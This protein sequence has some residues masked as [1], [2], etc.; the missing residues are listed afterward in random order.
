M[1]HPG[2]LQGDRTRL[3]Y[4]WYWSKPCERA[5]GSHQQTTAAYWDWPFYAAAIAVFVACISCTESS[6]GINHQPLQT[7]TQLVSRDSR[8]L[9]QVT[10][11]S[12][13]TAVDIKKGTVTAEILINHAHGDHVDYCSPAGA[14]WQYDLLIGSTVAAASQLVIPV[15]S[16]ATQQPFSVTLPLRRLAQR[17]PYDGYSAQML[18]RIY[19]NRHS[20]FQQAPQHQQHWSV[21]QDLSAGGPVVTWSGTW[22]AAG[23]QVDVQRLPRY[24]RKQLSSLAVGLSSDLFDWWDSGLSEQLEPL[25]YG[26]R[27]EAVYMFMLTRSC[28]C[29]IIHM[30]AM[31][32]QVVAVAYCCVIV[33]GQILCALLMQR[34]LCSRFHGAWQ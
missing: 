32:L 15:C 26:Q 24:G 29:R 21:L 23:M 11:H 12:T 7:V 33:L 3:A 31:L 9:Y 20:A 16:A 1:T 17:N 25:V 14:G 30:T 18:V 19:H 8:G 34:L 28:W 4:S 6:Y 10:L 5:A 27:D 22:T 2:A 13:V